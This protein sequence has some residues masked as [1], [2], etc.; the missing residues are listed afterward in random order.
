MNASSVNSVN[1]DLLLEVP[2][3]LSVELAAC[4]KSTAEVLALDVGSVV[5]FEGSSNDPV[6][7]FV[8][9]RLIALGELIV[10]QTGLGI[11][12]TEVIG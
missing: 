4:T 7:F 3:E 2:L 12:V 5:E 1:L 11:K 10:E 9:H 6:R 8:N